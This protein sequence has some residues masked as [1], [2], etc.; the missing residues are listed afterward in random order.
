MPFKI[1]FL[2]FKIAVKCGTLCKFFHCKSTFPDL[3]YSSRFMN[4]CTVY[5]LVSLQVNYYYYIVDPYFSNFRQISEITILRNTS[6]RCNKLYARENSK[7]LT[8]IQT[9]S[10][11][12]IRIISAPVLGKDDFGTKEG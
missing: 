7:I 1:L 11:S 2:I 9:R 5:D 8:A 10:C 3:A 6:S 4:Y 12:T